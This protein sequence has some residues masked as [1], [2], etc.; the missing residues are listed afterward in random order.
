MLV[1]LKYHLNCLKDNTFECF[2]KEY[3]RL[4]LFKKKKIFLQHI[5]MES[6]SL[7]EENIIKDIRNFFRLKKELSLCR[8][9]KL[10][11]FLSLK[12]KKIIKNQ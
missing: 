2:S 9:N 7:E 5:M 12:E 4:L 8:R 3:N 1:L 11:I 6:L 10:R